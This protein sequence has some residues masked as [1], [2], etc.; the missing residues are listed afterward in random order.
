[1]QQ[2]RLLLRER[3]GLCRLLSR[4]DRRFLFSEPFECLAH[5][6]TFRRGLLLE[7]GEHELERGARLPIFRVRLDHGG[8]VGLGLGQ[9]AHVGARDTPSKPGLD[10]GGIEVHGGGRGA[11]GALPLLGFDVTRG[12]VVVAR[13]QQWRRRVRLARV[14]LPPHAEGRLGRVG[15]QL[16]DGLLVRRSGRGKVTRGEIFVA[17]RLELVGLRDQAGDAI[18]GRRLD[19]GIPVRNPYLQKGLTC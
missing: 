15:C 12:Q 2:R 13:G 4:L 7:L 5:H 16:G 10:E 1:V 17:E 6:R 18:A 9:L 8:Q 3:L 14:A 11:Q 19:V